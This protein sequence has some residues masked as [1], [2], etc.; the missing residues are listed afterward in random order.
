MLKVSYAVLG[1]RL[2]KQG[3]RQYICTPA[4]LHSSMQI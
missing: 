3:E 1:A 2:S 4:G